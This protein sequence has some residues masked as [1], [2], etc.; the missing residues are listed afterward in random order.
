MQGFVSAAA[1]GGFAVPAAALIVAAPPL[2]LDARRLGKTSA[3]TLER[4]S[5]IIAAGRLIHELQRE[6]GLSVGFLSKPE[7]DG[8]AVASQRQH[9]DTAHGAFGDLFS[10]Q[11]ADPVN[12][13]VTQALNGLTAHRHSVDSR[14]LTPT[15]AALGYSGRIGTLLDLIALGVKSSARGRLARLGTA[16]LNLISAK[17]AAGQERAHLT[18]LLAAPN[19]EAAARRRAHDLREQQD[20]LL[21]LFAEGAGSELARFSRA[22]LAD[23]ERVVT[24]L[25]Y[26][27][28]SEDASVHRPTAAMWFEAA[29]RRIDALKEVEMRLEETMNHAALAVQGRSRR[30]LR[31]LLAAVLGSAGLLGGIAT[32]AAGVW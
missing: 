28:L 24:S 2:F 7:G 10:R 11:P 9:T 12:D 20:M 29:T 22:T 6:R 21:K 1:L 25:R 17:E 18:G 31:W 5:L 13:A 32:A 26:G 8:T 27:A 15:Q 4:I 19:V 14:K 23:S 30:N 3:Q 16:Y